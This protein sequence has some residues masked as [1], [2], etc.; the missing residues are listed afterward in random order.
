MKFVKTI[1]NFF[2]TKVFRRLCGYITE[3][4]LKF[5]NIESNFLMHVDYN[6]LNMRVV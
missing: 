1:K 4:S 3:R 6:I 2:H 5:V